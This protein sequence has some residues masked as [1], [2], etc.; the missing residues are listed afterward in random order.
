MEDNLRAFAQEAERQ[1]RRLAEHARGL[2]IV[3]AAAQLDEKA[4]RMAEMLRQNPD[5]AEAPRA[6]VLSEAAD[7]LYVLGEEIHNRLT[8][9]PPASL[10]DFAELVHFVQAR[11]ERLNVLL[12]LERRAASG[13]LDQGEAPPQ[14]LRWGR[15][16]PI[17]KEPPQFPTSR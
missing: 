17:S 4:D 12:R 16:T 13:S 14:R 2:G 11:A 1:Y 7:E 3:R 9:W 10:A 6:S 5:V 15:E 8:R